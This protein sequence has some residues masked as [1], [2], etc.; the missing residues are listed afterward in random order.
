MCLKYCYVY[1]KQCRPLSDTAFCSVIWVY[2]A[3][4][5]LPAPILRHSKRK[6]FQRPLFR[7]AAKWFRYSCLPWKYIS[8]HLEMIRCVLLRKAHIRAA[9]WE[10]VFYGKHTEIILRSVCTFVQSDQSS[11]GTPWIAKDPRLLHSEDIRLHGC[12]NWSEPLQ[13]VSFTLVTHLCASL[14]GSVGCA[15]DWRPG[16]QGF[17]PRWEWQHS[18][19]EIDLEIFSRVILSFHWFK[20]GSCQF[21]VKECAQYWW[22]N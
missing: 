4:K 16:C 11:Q 10:N 9:T 12:T 5:G 17:D 20:K 7:R 14:S 6:E 15:S 3:C 18:F 1:G 22:T 8:T 2:T 13:G 21:L 19:V